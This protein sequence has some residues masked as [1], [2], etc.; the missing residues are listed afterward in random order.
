VDIVDR[1]RS[2]G[3]PEQRENLGV[4][5]SVG[6]LMLKAADEIERLRQH[7]SILERYCNRDTLAQV[8]SAYETK[9]KTGKFPFED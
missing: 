5:P 7:N 4:L 9:R 3:S 8:E 6:N 2:D 1:L